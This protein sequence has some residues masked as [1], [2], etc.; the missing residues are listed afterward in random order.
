MEELA[1]ESEAIGRHIAL[2]CEQLGIRED[3]TPNGLLSHVS[4]ERFPSAA[5]LIPL[6]LELIDHLHHRMQC[7][8]QQCSC[9]F[10]QQCHSCI[11]DICRYGVSW[12]HR[13]HMTLTCIQVAMC[14]DSFHMSFCCLQTMA[15]LSSFSFS[16]FRSQFG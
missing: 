3:L 6:P 7:C 13:E 8:G 11:Y 15:G 10:H 14:K 9:L 1:E 5:P 12:A 2:A 16:L 4:S